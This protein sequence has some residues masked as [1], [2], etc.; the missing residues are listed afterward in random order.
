ML[1]IAYAEDNGGYP[2]VSFEPVYGNTS[3]DAQV[4]RATDGT[5]L[6]GWWFSN[7]TLPHARFAEVPPKGVLRDP[8]APGLRDGSMVGPMRYFCDYKLSE[9]LFAEPRYWN[10]D[11]QIG[12]RQWHV[13]RL[14]QIQFPSAKGLARQITVYDIEGYP[15]GYPGCCV[16]QVQAP[17]LWADVSATPEVQ[18]GLQPGVPN[19]W[20]HGHGSDRVSIWARGVPIDGTQDGVLGMDR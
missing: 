16:Q 8:A 15:D 13:Q 1:T 11:T 4:I 14:E 5:E 10:R 19:F 12:V 3:G 9:T 6:R 7:A 20:H 2:P 17:V 18:A